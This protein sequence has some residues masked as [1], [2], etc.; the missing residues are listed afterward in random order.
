MKE[1]LT[2]VWGHIMEAGSTRYFLIKPAIPKPTH[3][4][5][6]A[7]HKLNPHPKF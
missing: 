5:E 2:S 3:W 4:V 6:N 1:V 7:R